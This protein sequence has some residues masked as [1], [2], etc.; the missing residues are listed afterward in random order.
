MEPFMLRYGETEVAVDLSAARSVTV[1]KGNPP[2]E[3]DDLP[4]AFWRAITTD[5]VDSPALSQLVGPEDEV[6][7][8]IS[9]ITRYW[10]RQDLICELLVD[11][12]MHEAG[13]KAEQIVILVALGTHRPMTEAELEKL[14]GSRLYG[15][16]QVVNH[17]CEAPDLRYLGITS[18]GT[19]VFVNP[20][21]CGRKVILIGGTVHHLMAGYGGGRKSI[22]PGVSAKS[23]I[24]QNHLMCLDPY[25]AHSSETIGARKLAGNP[26]HE[27]MMEA[28]AMVAPVFGINLLMGPNGKHARLVC[29][30]WKSAWEESCRLADAFSGAPIRKKADVVVVSCGGYPKDINLYQAVKSLLNAARCLRGGGTMIFLARCEEGG[31]APDFF[32]WIESLKAGTLD[33]DLR[34]RFTIAGYIFYASCEAIERCQ[35]MALTELPAQTL[36]EMGLRGFFSIEELMSQVDLSGKDVYVMPMGGNTVPYLEDEAAGEE[37]FNRG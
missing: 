37:F 12:L 23:T 5:C 11:F 14:V 29:G 4:M 32:D 15:Q 28:A 36:R 21:V 26:V 33:H 34:E 22:L 7:I 3:L 10:M 8:V 27:D 16:V 24:N 18:F 17:D 30:N 19:Q 25:E 20:L 9:D 31:G 1:L 2:E 6:T 35:V 13:M